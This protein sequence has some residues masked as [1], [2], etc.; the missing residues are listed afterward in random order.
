MAITQQSPRPERV[1][2]TGNEAVAWA[3]V[4][5]GAE[6]M[7]GYPI[8]PQN[9]IMHTWV[10]LAHQYG[11]DFLQ[12]EDE[13]SAGF[14]T[15][16]GVLAGKVAFTATA[17]PG[18]VLMQEPLSMAE[19]M[20]LPVVVVVCQ[21]GGPSTGTVI[22][23]QQEVMLA[24]FG[25]NGEGLRVVYAPATHQELYDYTIKAFRVAWKYRFPTI[26]LSDGYQAK[27]REALTVYRVEDQVRGEA[28]VGRP[29]VPGVA[30][31]PAHLRNTYN[32]E[33]EL[34]DLL[35]NYTTAFQEIQPRV[36]EWQEE[37]WQG[38]E[39][40]VVAHGVV[41][42][43]ARAAVRELRGEGYPVGYFRPVTLRPFP[44]EV[45]RRWA[46]L[47]GTMLVVESAAGQLRRLVAEAL[48]GYGF[49]LEGLLRPG[50]GITPEEIVAVARGL[51]AAN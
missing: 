40:L 27:M 19:M 20:R 11:L 30:R 38:A 22:Y 25:G 33:E 10:R 6:I 1:F 37:D 2:W 24:C 12:T 9:E 3:A 4:A 35:A 32:L 14:A 44:A 16:G 34:Y 50:V 29:G 28:Y 26:V 5:A 31:P 13:L 8:T 21:R 46:S 17:G 36:G 51:L 15:L 47:G 41:T 23:S 48:A 39:L 42:R 45:L 43:A 49:R 7:C 18:T